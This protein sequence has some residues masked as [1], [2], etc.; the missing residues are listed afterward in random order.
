MSTSTIAPASSAPTPSPWFRSARY[1]LLLIL[2]V[3]FVTWPLLTAARM[4]WGA[5]LLTKLILLTAT[6]H[7]LATFVRAYGDRDLF[8]RF[9]VRFLVAPVVLLVTCVGLNA[10]GNGPQLMLP[11]AAWAFWHW[12]AQAFGFARI[13]DIKVG[14]F[15]WFTALLD[16]ALVVTGF[17][18]AVTLND[19]A[20]VMFGKLFLTAGVAL[21]SASTVDAVQTVV[22]V[23]C[24][25]VGITYVVNLGAAIVRGKPWSWQK[26]FMHVTTIGYYWFAF[27]WLPNVLIAHVL[28]EF[29]HDVQ[30]FAITWITCKSRVKRPGVTTWLKRMFSP[31]KM[32]AVLFLV[33]MVAFGAL[34]AFGRHNLADGE[35]G[36]RIWIGIFLT[37]AL[38][39]YYYDGFI[40]KARER[41]LGDDLGTGSGV[42]AAVVPGMRHA[43]AWSAFFVPLIALLSIDGL[44][45]DFNEKQ[46]AEA[47]LEVAPDDFYN[48]LSLGY[49][50]AAERRLPEALQHYERSV[51]LNGD[52]APTR[53]NYGSALELHGDL[54]AAIEQYRACLECPDKND[55]HGQA[56]INLGVLL[57]M[58][59]DPESLECFERGRE[60][61]AQGPIHRMLGMAAGVLPSE[62]ERR[63]DYYQA[64]LKLKPGQPN[65]LLQ[66]GFVLIEMG[67][68]RAATK[69]LEQFSRATPAHV[70]AIL[71]LS[72]T[73]FETGRKDLAR[74]TLGRAMTLEPQSP[75]VARLKAKFGMR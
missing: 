3:P 15:H 53:V 2:G 10:N 46:T 71:A 29:F 58:R 54:D 16:K 7:Y 8:A 69:H 4:N 52:F 12:L 17:L 14:S 27:S 11:V 72:D 37:A 73:Y 64:A 55:A 13:Y 24:F 25:V 74:T 23:L 59:D 22:T 75:H 9:R 32:A 6:G 38:L 66:L 65:A 50:L 34:D 51:E 42:R 45:Q 61:G 5:D 1:D 31:T 26:Q 49:I 67:E 48:R 70:P 19:G 35:L 40:W 28:Y 68:F 57:L 33:L 63:R 39:H 44:N 60:L 41:S 62:R 20:I 47:L 18:A 43:V 56:N 21:P 30:Y 36:E